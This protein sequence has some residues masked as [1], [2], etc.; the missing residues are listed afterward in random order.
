MVHNCTLFELCHLSL[1]N[2]IAIS[3]SSVDYGRRPRNIRKD[4]N[5]STSLIPAIRL[6][7]VGFHA[8]SMEGEQIVPSLIV[9]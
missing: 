5:D 3:G 1:T 7:F 2:S 6:L 4:D 8:C 9:N